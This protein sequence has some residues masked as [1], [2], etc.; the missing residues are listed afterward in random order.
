MGLKIYNTADP[1]AS[2]SIGGTFATPFSVSFDGVFGGV[3]AVKRYVRNDDAG[4]YYTGIQVLPVM[5][6]GASLIDGTDGWSWKL[7]AGDTQPLESEWDII[8]DANTISLADLGSAGTPDTSTYLPFWVRISIPEGASVESYQNIA[9]RI[10][11]T[12][13]SI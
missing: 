2:F 12:G 13:N 7:K 11:S 9:L 1:G 3:R 6:S 8:N 10:N 5:L 4:L